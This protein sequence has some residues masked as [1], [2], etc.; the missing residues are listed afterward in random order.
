MA[1]LHDGSS[2]MIRP[3]GLPLPVTIDTILTDFARTLVQLNDAQLLMGLDVLSFQDPRDV[4][5]H[6]AMLT[7][8]AR[9]LG[10]GAVVDE[11]VNAI[12]AQCV[13]YRLS[14]ARVEDGQLFTGD[15]A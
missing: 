2:G 1:D 5:N 11:L 4:L 13:A 7:V 10:A 12:G 15:E 8:N 3:P 6:L 14:R 9:T